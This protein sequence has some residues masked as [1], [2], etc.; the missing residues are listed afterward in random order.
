MKKYSRSF[1]IFVLP[2]L[3][4][5]E[6]VFGQIIKEEELLFGEKR[7]SLKKG[8]IHLSVAFLAKE[9]LLDK[10]KEIE[11]LDYNGLFEDQDVKYL[12]SKFQLE[13][14][15]PITF[16]SR[17]TLHN[18]KGFEKLSKDVKVKSFSQKSKTQIDLVAEKKISLFT[19]RSE[20]SFYYMDEDDYQGNDFVINSLESLIEGRRPQAMTMI[21]TANFSKY[22]K[23][24]VSLC[25]Y[26]DIDRVLM[27]CFTL[28]SLG[29]DVVRKYG[30]VVDFKKR[31]RE[32]ILYTAKQIRKMEQ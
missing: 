16:F 1:I 2:L 27:T 24:A 21:S 12:F 31:F 4:L 22:F 15:K 6:P 20:A 14:K 25:F 11:D 7:E 18:P 32:E 5:F 30:W 28:M 26:E 13:V 9:K 10:A 29:N 3:F 23:K 17:K 8:N 19:I